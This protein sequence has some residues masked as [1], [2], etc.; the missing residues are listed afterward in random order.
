MQ[1]FFST[2]VDWHW[3]WVVKLSLQI[4][5]LIYFRPR[6]KLWAVFMLARKMVQTTAL[7]QSFCGKRLGKSLVE[8]QEG[9]FQGG[10]ALLVWILHNPNDSNEQRSS[11][12]FCF[13]ILNMSSLWVDITIPVL[14]VITAGKYLES[15]SGFQIKVTQ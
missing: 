6:K 2:Q 14:L 9:L 15:D 8:C 5:K 3:E 13:F 7:P 10:W 4:M 11:C 12:K 1:S